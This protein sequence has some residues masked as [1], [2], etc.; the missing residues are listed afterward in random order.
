[1]ITETIQAYAAQEIERH[2]ALRELRA[3][4]Y[5]AEKAEALLILVEGTKEFDAIREFYR[6]GDFFELGESQQAHIDALIQAI[7]VDI[8]E[9]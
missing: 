9:A 2:D 6:T 5:P 1:M 7:L 3:E 4:G 8:G